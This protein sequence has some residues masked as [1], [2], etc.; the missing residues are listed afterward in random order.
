MKYK[1]TIYYLILILTTLVMMWLLPVLVAKL[2]YKPDKYPFVYYSTI[3]DELAIMNYANER[4]MSDKKGNTYTTSEM[5]SLLPML[6]YRQLM[7]DGRLPD[8]IRGQ[9]MNVRI[10]RSKSFTFRYD[11]SEINTPTCE[12][13]IL[14]EAMPK[15]VGLTMPEDV[16]RMKDKIEFIDTETNTVNE[17]KSQAF[18][19]EL[20]KNKYSFPSRWLVGNPNPRKPYDEGY[21]SLDANGQLY[22]IKMVNGRPYVKNTGVG[23]DIDI[24]YFSMLEV[25]DKRFY[26]FLFSKQG[27]MYIIQNE[28][29]NYETLKLEIPPI[30]LEKDQVMIMGNPF[31][32]TV[33]I[34]NP[35]GKQSYGL[36]NESLKQI[37]EY[38]IP[39]VSSKWDNVSKWIFP[40]YLT[41]ESKNSDYL[42]PIIHFTG[43]YALIL[44][45]ILAIGGGF[46]F[47][48]TRKKRAFK[49]LYIL[50]TGLAGFVS[51]LLLPK[52]RKLN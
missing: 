49:I 42:I 51:L 43:F 18:Q 31:E 28:I 19:A 24:A 12:L 4:P 13:Y 36:Q 20:D 21:F 37:D 9:E 38:H 15:R 45:V 1:N 48:D 44:N 52:T 32:W 5:D 16:F 3:L 39:R 2:T 40:A 47:Y 23:E 25:P 8:S 7:S 11:P 10:I 27:E 6:N 30:D 26:G 17:E 34:T 35:D 46:Y 41:L 14:F 22:H 29:G 50:V 33:S